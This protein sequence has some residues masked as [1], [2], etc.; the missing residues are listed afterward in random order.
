MPTATKIKTAPARHRAVAKT[1]PRATSRTSKV[2]PVSEK[3]PRPK[4]SPLGFELF[5]YD[6]PNFILTDEA[7][8]RILYGEP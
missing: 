8:N 5:Y 4:Y 1:A 2:I 3:D 7:V 6:D